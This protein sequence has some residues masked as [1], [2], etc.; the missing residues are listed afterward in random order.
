ME[1][2]RHVLHRVESAILTLGIE[3]PGMP[4]GGWLKE[5]NAI[6]ELFHA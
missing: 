4:T 2:F 1:A 6:D 3:G 5:Q